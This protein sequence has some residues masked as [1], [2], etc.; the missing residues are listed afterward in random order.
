MI[1]RQGES[2]KSRNMEISGRALENIW[3]EKTS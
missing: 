1:I 2:I 3:H